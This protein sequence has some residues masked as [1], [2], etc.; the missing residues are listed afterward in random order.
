MKQLLIALDALK[1]QVEGMGRLAA[2]MVADA[3]AVADGSGGVAVTRVRTAESQLDTGQVSAD[4]AAIRLI[5]VHTPVARDLRFVITI[6]RITSELERMGDEAVNIVDALEPLGGHIPASA[7][8]ARLSAVVREMLRQA[9]LAFS[10]EDVVT[11]R[12]VLAKD[13]AAD[14]AAADIL[15]ALMSGSIGD[16]EPSPRL[17]AALAVRALERIADHATNICEEVVYLVDGA[18]IRHQPV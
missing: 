7:D 6:V 10:N 17:R 2:A 1:E 8:V 9:L 4:A 13:D 3:A 18:D 15:M 16:G 12:A 5:T 11:A 14:S